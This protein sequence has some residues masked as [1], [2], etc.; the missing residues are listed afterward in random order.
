MNCNTHAHAAPFLWI[1]LT[2]QIRSR[3]IDSSS[4]E[5]CDFFVCQLFYWKSLL[6]WHL[7]YST[8]PP[9]SQWITN[10]MP[11]PSAASIE[12]WK[13]E[14]GQLVIGVVS[15]AIFLFVQLFLSLWMR[16]P[17]FFFHPSL[18][19]FIAPCR[20]L[21]RLQLKTKKEAGQLSTLVVSFS[22]LYLLY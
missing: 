15:F 2:I 7:S 6:R 17:A 22:V 14:A 8:P 9:H 21:P 1:N 4:G 13:R 5:F 18:P 20:T 10:P 19:D 16:C 3:L 12:S 11:C